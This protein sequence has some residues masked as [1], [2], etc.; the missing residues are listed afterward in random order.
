LRLDFKKD[1][2]HPSPLGPSIL[3]PPC[4]SIAND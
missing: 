3:T 1:P 4:S 2:I